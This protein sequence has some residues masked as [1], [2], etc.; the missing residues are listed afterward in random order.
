[1]SHSVLSFLLTNVCGIHTS[2]TNSV[3]FDYPCCKWK[4]VYRSATLY[5]LH[6][7]ADLGAKVW[8]LY[9]PRWCWVSSTTGPI[10]TMNTN[11]PKLFCS[12]EV[13]GYLLVY[14]LNPSGGRI[15]LCEISRNVKQGSLH[16][17]S[18]IGDPSRNGGRVSAEQTASLE[19]VE[20][21]LKLNLTLKVNA[22]CLPF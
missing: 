2:T 6:H 16:V 5:P 1:M 14:T 18:K 3:D 22:D 7:R 17:G 4:L 15:T 19:L 21:W 13:C 20:I 8:F 12:R 10:Y 9:Q 11:P